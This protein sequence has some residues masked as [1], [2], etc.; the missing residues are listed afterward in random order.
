MQMQIRTLD[1]LI[2]MARQKARESGESSPVLHYN[3]MSR[4]S[5]ALF[6]VSVVPGLADGERNVSV[7]DHVLDLLAH[8]YMSV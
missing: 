7:L 1:K 6:A 8:C 4:A 3:F 5:A 2:N